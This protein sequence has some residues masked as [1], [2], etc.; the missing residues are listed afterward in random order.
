MEPIQVITTTASLNQI[1][2][3]SKFPLTDTFSY[4]DSCGVFSIDGK[5][6]QEIEEERIFF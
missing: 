5:I 3:H 6:S 2:R 1:Q 4:C